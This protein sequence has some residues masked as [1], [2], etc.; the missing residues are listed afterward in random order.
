[1]LCHVMNNQ[2]EEQACAVERET[3]PKHHPNSQSPEPP[4]AQ[5]LYDN[6]V[7]DQ[8]GVRWAMDSDGEMHRFSKPSNGKTH[9]NG[10]TR[11]RDPIKPQNIPADI[12]RRFG[13]KG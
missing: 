10:S 7:A 13:Y 12:K 3:N 11:G 8:K 4:N 6:S 2:S 1:M 5:G 9:W